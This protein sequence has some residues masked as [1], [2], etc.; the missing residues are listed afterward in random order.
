MRRFAFLFVLAF[1]ALGVLPAK[2]L[3]YS[4]LDLENIILLE[5]KTGTVV[6]ETRPTLAPKHVARIKELT[7]Q[8]FYDG[9]VFHRVID[10]FMAQTGDP[11]GTGTGGSGQNI[12]AEFN[13]LKHFR[14]T[15]SMARSGDPDSADSQ[16]FIMLATGFGL[17]GH[18]SICGRVIDGMEHVDQITNGSPHNDG[19]VQDPDRIVRMRVAADVMNPDGTMKEGAQITKPE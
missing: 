7:R 2:A 8:E 1:A 13:R 16:F 4:K 9:I 10:G 14:G 17:D 5:L 3:D 19:I 12:P 6:I 15:V 11:T 18:Y